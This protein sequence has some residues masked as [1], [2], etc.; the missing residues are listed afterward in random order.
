M[1]SCD[2]MKTRP[3]KKVAARAPEPSWSCI[4]AKRELGS[5]RASPLP[6]SGISS[7]LIHTEGSK[8]FLTF[9]S[10]SGNKHA[11][12]ADGRGAEIERDCL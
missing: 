2:R 3:K 7:V 11:N 9:L 12:D 4:A 6:Y 8:M 1:D 10:R 5:Q